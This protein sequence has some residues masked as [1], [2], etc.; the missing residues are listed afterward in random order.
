MNNV[1]PDMWGSAA[2]KL[3]DD[4]IYREARGDHARVRSIRVCQS[5][6]TQCKFQLNGQLSDHVRDL[7]GAIPTDVLIL[8]IETTLGDE[9]D[10][11]V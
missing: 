5:C 10:L 3:P 4:S 8:R 9:Y 11:D 6:T 7:V 1:Q 2:C